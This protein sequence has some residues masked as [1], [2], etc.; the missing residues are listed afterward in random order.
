MAS[1]AQLALDQRRSERFQVR[2]AGK[3]FVPAEEIT[4]DCTIINLSV[5]GAGIYCPE[6][7]PLDC[8]VVLYIDSFGRFEGATTRYVEGELGLRFVCKEAKRQRLEQDLAAFVAD[9][10]TG[11]TR[12]RRHRRT[13]AQ[14]Q[15]DHFTTSNGFKTVCKLMDI[16]LQGAMLKTM[17]R[18]A[19]GE[20]IQL[21]QTRAWVVRHHD[22]GIGV[23]F[24]QPFEG[25][26]GQ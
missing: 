15:I 22:E 11:V 4:L 19:I 26:Q 17:A 21:G 12:L 1:N 5:G 24:Q 16:S 20:P 8:F 10:M 14:V 25:Q 6:P 18:P 9:G 13:A 7:P 3:L 23:Q 2:L